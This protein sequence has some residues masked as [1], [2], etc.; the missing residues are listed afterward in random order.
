MRKAKLPHFSH[1]FLKFVVFE[2]LLNPL[3]ISLPLSLFFLISQSSFKLFTRQF[4]RLLLF[5]L[6][7]FAFQIQLIDTI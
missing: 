3:R 5:S 6:K 2:L 1:K 7:A 4:P